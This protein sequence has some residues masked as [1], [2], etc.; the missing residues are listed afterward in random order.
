MKITLSTILSIIPALAILLF[1]IFYVTGV[2]NLGEIPGLIGVLNLPSLAIIIGGLL[3]VELISFPPKQVFD[4][5]ARIRYFFSHSTF[6]DSNLKQDIASII[7]WQKEIRKNKLT[8]ANTLSKELGDS[9]EAYMFTLI[10][11]NYSVEEVQELGEAK[12]AS[13]YQKNKRHSRVFASLANVSPAFGMFGTLLGLII[14]LQNFQETTQLGMGLGVALMTTLY[15]LGLSQLFWLPLEKK[16]T[17]SA[18]QNAEREQLVLEGILLIMKEKP[19]LYIKD[20]LTA[21]LQ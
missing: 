21:S 8:S 1:G 15:G 4:A 18:L 10:A 5:L 19:S 14:M 6:D 2:I 12:I 20:Y 13:N 17:N 11:T 9:F 16:I 7:S 3:T